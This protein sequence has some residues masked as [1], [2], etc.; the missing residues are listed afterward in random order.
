MSPASATK[1]TTWPTSMFSLRVSLKSSMAS[2]WVSTAPSPS[3]ATSWASSSTS[4]TNC[5]D[6][7][8]KSVSD[9]S[10]TRAPRLS[11][12]GRRQRRPRRSR[13]RPARPPCP[14]PAR[15][16]TWRR[17][18]SHRRSPPALCLASIIPAPVASRSAFTSL[19]VN[20]AMPCLYSS[21]R[22]VP[23]GAGVAAA[24][25][26]RAGGS[27][28]RGRRVGWAAGAAAW[29]RVTWAGG[30]IG[31]WRARAPPAVQRPDG[32]QPP[33]AAGATGPAPRPS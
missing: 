12:H 10:S 27:G 1:R 32:P 9:F 18:R 33:L 15:A 24:H 8:T 3:A 20:S 25:G 22:C 29:G 19:A 5:G 30:A 11:P 16:A 21:V 13:G 4:A 6:L 14:D 17:R 2:L 28:R 7:A 23:V 26:R 31:G